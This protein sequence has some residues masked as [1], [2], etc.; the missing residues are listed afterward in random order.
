MNDC[1]WPTKVVY[2]V[3]VNVMLCIE[4]LLARLVWVSCRTVRRSLACTKDEGTREKTDKEAG[5]LARDESCRSVHSARHPTF[6]DCLQG[7]E[8]DVRPG[9]VR[10]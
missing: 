6:L 5:W 1:C 2:K 10:G 3:G 7:R 9:H 4:P 8:G